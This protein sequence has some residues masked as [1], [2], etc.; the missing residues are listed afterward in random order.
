MPCSHREDSRL[1]GPCP[2]RRGPFLQPSEVTRTPTRVNEYC[3]PSMRP[4]AI[5]LFSAAAPTS[6]TV[7]HTRINGPL[8]GVEDCNPDAH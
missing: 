1:L 6:F 4:L 2:S 3:R 7:R 5:E 8:A